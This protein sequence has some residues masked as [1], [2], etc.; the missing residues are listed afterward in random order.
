MTETETKR[1][2]LLALMEDYLEALV[3]KNA[4]R[5]PVAESCKITYNGELS[6]LGENEF[7]KNSLVIK[8]RQTF[9]DPKEG[10]MVFFGVTTN[11][12]F[13]RDCP[14]E[15]GVKLYAMFYTATI[16]LR[17]VDGL[18]VEIEELASDKRLR[19]FM[20]EKWDIHLPELHFKI[21]VPEEERS[22][23]QEMIDMIDV[24]WDCAA[25][26]A[27]P[28]LMKI[29]PDAQRFE[30][31]FRTTNHSRSFRG[32][33][34][35]NPGFIWNTKHRRYPVIDEERGVILSYCMMDNPKPDSIDN[36][37]GGLV[38]E[39]FRIENGLITFLFAFFPFLTGPV[40]WE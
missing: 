21:P 3:E 32:D 29:H 18:I 5:L 30:E 27:D 36:R 34:K 19:Y 15:V 38:C 11:E 23:R 7:W 33:F 24:Y 28:N 12:L 37:R 13:E 26:W 25:K 9:V 39:V 4:A 6:P 2:A 40:G 35:H 8:E 14:F 1:R 10:Q 20:G 16:R 17:V 31:G 22:T